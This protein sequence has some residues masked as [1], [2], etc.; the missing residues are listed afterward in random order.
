[1][2]YKQTDTLINA[3]TQ[4]IQN[5][6]YSA[7]VFDETHDEGDVEFPNGS[8]LTLGNMSSDIDKYRYQGKQFQYVGFRNPDQFSDTQR[9]YM[10][11]RLRN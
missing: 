3:V 9:R 6:N 1:M 5:P 2:C 10:G 4:C 11:S 8:V 7:I